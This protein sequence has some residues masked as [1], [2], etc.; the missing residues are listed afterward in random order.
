MDC[1]HASMHF[2]VII[3]IRRASWQLPG[4]TASVVGMDHPP[5]QGY[6]RGVATAPPMIYFNITGNSTFPSEFAFSTYLLPGSRPP[7]LPCQ[8]VAASCSV[9]DL[10]A[11]DNST[12][13]GDSCQHARRHVCKDTTVIATLETPWKHLVMESHALLM[14][15]PAW[16]VHVLHCCK[17]R[18]WTCAAHAVQAKQSA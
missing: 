5:A 6:Y 8:P 3:D 2:W 12:V 17:L 9:A 4:N 18:D 1:C 11:V 13:T 16:Q 15:A 14:D 10:E 7:P